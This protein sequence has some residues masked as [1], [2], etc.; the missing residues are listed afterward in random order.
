M[1]SSPID[2]RNALTPGATSVDPTTGAGLSDEQIDDAIRQADSRI[3]GYLPTGYVVPTE[4]VENGLVVAI[5]PFRYWSRD[6]AAYLATLTYKRNKDVPQD[7]PVRL[8][9]TDAMGDLILVSRGTFELPAMPSNPTA[10]VGDV[11]VYNQYEGRLFGPEDFALAPVS[12]G[13][14]VYQQYIHDVRP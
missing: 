14:T 12:G 6:I 13:R 3:N 1:Y 9:Y 11:F 10:L 5:A 7:E 2:V 4:T 8:R